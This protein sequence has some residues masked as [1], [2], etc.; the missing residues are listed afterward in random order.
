MKLLV[1]IAAL[2]LQTPAP[3][4]SVNGTVIVSGTSE[5]IADADVA[6]VTPDGV[7]ETTTDAG[8]RFALD[9]VPA[10]RHT[11]LIRADG[12]FIEPTTPN[13][14]FFA[15]AEVP[16][17]V[18][19]GG[20]PVAIPN[21]SMVRGGTISG[22][23]LDP[24]GRPLPFVRVQALR[25]SG[26]TTNSGVM[27]DFANR[28][29]DDR[30]EYRMFF[31][32]PG[33]YVVRAQVQ[34]GRPAGPVQT[35]PGQMETLVST[36]FP[37]TTDMAQAGKVV[38]KPGEEV[39]GIDISVKMEIVNLPPPAPKPTGGVK[40]SGLV[41]DG[42][43]PIIGTADL[44]LGSEAD[45]APPRPVGS[46]IIGGTPGAFEIPNVQPGKYDLFARMPHQAG[47]PGPG[48]GVLAWGRTTVEVRDQDV[49]GIRMVVHPS[50]DVPGVVK[51]DG[52]LAPAG[53]T[54]K[55]GLSAT[56]TAGRLGNYRGILDRT[57]NPDANGKVTIPRAAEGNYQFFIQAADDLYIADVRQGDTSILASGI[58]VR[59]AAP[60]PFEMLL[61]SGGSTVEGVV[62]NA[63]KSPVN[64]AMVLLVPADKQ[65][66]RA[67]KTAT[68]GADGKYAF[69]GVRPGEYKVFA[70]PPGALPPGGLTLELLSTIEPRGTSVTVKAG[71]SAVADVGVITN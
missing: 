49:D 27:P 52:K 26:G 61:A 57:Q 56:G 69:R 70:G 33:E 37:D 68:A 50:M 29:T 51:I 22:K 18:T 58:D 65:L 5:P 62:S 45:S 53:G 43:L 40:I 39:R 2:L 14:P 24:Q 10:G 4:G 54:L 23:V 13:I 55:I 16:V 42:L 71:A 60:A 17:N 8:G 25:P 44:L 6:I 36:L 11:L 64:G 59:N 1:L 20:A 35:R 41:V 31:V 9:N 30:G 48:G 46:V 47:S 3:R 34:G 12:F 32:P 28:M 15:R 7:L 67:Y 21:V 19:A 38:V 63:D 66:F